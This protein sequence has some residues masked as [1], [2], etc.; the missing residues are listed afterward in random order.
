MAALINDPSHK[1]KTYNNKHLSFYAT[2]FS[3]SFH[4]N[5]ISRLQ[6]LDLFLDKLTTRTILS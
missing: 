3:T 6:V 4:R 1:I 2:I 5:L